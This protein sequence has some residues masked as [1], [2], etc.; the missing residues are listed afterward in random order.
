MSILLVY[1]EYRLGISDNSK[2]VQIG[3]NMLGEKRSN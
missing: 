2:F 3:I 1:I